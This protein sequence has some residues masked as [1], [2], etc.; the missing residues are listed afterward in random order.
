MIRTV[1]NG[2][3][4]C[5]GTRGDRF[6]L[7]SRRAKES[8]DFVRRNDYK[9]IILD[10]LDGFAANDLTSLLPLKAFIEELTIVGNSISYKDLGEFSK[11]T[12]LS[13]L[14]NG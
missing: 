4:V 1:E 14:D 8:V 2:F 10:R 13:A 12:L 3:K 11:L 6:L 9:K 5:P 7:D